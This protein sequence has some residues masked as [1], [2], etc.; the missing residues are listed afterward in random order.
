M[1]KLTLPDQIETVGQ[2]VRWLRERASLSLRA[3]AKKVG[4]SAPFLSDLERD[5]RATTKTDELAAALGCSPD[6]LRA[7][8]GRLSTELRH[9]IAANPGMVAVLREMKAGDWRR[10]RPGPPRAP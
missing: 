5:R 4:V 7:F 10:W 6:V 2:A 8:D 9:W 3:L 1:D